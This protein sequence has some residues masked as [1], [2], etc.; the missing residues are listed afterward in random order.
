MAN[1]F[2]FR[3]KSN[4]RAP[5]LKLTAWE[6]REMQNHPDYERVDEFGEVVVSFDDTEGTIPFQGATGRK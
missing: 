5:I 6:A 1:T 4:P 2:F 3:C